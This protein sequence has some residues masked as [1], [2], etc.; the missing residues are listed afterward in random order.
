MITL[1]VESS[2]VLAWLLGERSSAELVR[3]INEADAIVTSVLTLLESERALIRAEGQHLLTAAESQKL[4]GMLA[5]AAAS[6][7]L[8]EISADVVR[9]AARTFPKEPVPTLDALHLA[10]AL[11]FLQAFP[12]LQVLTLDERIVA[13]CGALGI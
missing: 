3:R 2:A 4:R 1:Y 9:G 8:M 11:L 6:W 12:D 13:N 7:V 10:T 5:R